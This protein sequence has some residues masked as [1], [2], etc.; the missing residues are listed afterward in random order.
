MWTQNHPLKG[1]RGPCP[2]TPFTGIYGDRNLL[3]GNS[4][5]ETGKAKRGG[6]SLN[7][8]FRKPSRSF[9]LD[10]QKEWRG[11]LDR[12]ATNESLGKLASCPRT[13]SGIPGRKL[14]GNIPSPGRQ[15]GGAIPSLGTGVL[16]LGGSTQI[17]TEI[18]RGGVDQGKQWGNIG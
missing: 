12:T 7:P 17:V 8:F 15:L 11:D 3:A 6:G 16:A 13:G 10:F 2:D 1:V 4:K 5:S 18:Q 9:S 14:S